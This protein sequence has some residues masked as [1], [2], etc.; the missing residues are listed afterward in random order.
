MYIQA[1]NEKKVDQTARLEL[2]LELCRSA[3]ERREISP[4]DRWVS[5][6]VDLCISSSRLVNTY[7]MRDLFAPPWHQSVFSLAPRTHTHTYIATLDVSSIRGVFIG[8][9]GGSGKYA[10]SKPTCTSMFCM[11]YV[12]VLQGEVGMYVVQV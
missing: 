7:M 3:G 1:R 2:E 5:C 9:G 8:G 6:S 4:T 12:K 11:C 10:Q